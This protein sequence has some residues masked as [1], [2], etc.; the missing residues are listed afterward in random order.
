LGALYVTMLGIGLRRGEALGLRWADGDLDRAT[1]VVQRALKYE[2][3]DGKTLLV[4]GEVKTVKSKRAPNLP[5]PVTAALRG[6]RTPGTE[7]RA[8]GRAWDD[9]GLGLVFSTALG[10]PLDPRNVYR[11]FVTVCQ[12]AGL[13]RWHPHELRHSAASIMLAK[14]VPIEGRVRLCR[15]HA[16]DRG[17][18]PIYSPVTVPR[19]LPKP[20]DSSRSVVMGGL[21]GAADVIVTPSARDQMRWSLTVGHRLVN[22][23]LSHIEGP[24]GDGPC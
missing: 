22:W 1:V 18:T 11:D 19:T 24:P 10:G 14:G 23:L 8:A 20:P 21:M 2:K 5:A 15:Q 9:S 12:R 17:R 6:Q 3:R 16:L 13:G 7:R 4:L